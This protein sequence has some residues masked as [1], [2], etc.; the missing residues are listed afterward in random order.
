M[1]KF[2][3]TL[4]SFLL[5][6]SASAGGEGF[7]AYTQSG[8]EQELLNLD[9]IDGRVRNRQTAVQWED[10]LTVPGWWAR[11]A[12]KPAE[13]FELTHASNQ[14]GGV[15]V[16]VD[17]ANNQP[18]ALG[19]LSTV[20]VPNVLLAVAVKNE[21]G[22]V[23]T[24]AT[25]RLNRVQWFGGTGAMQDS[26]TGSWRL[27]GATAGGG[28]WTALEGLNMQHF[29]NVGGRLPEPIYLE[30]TVHLD[31]IKW[32]PGQLLWLRW[33]D[34]RVSGGNAA[35][36]IASLRIVGTAAGQGATAQGTVVVTTQVTTG[37]TAQ[38]VRKAP[39]A[40]PSTTQADGRYCWIPAQELYLEGRGWSDTESFFD[41]LPVHAKGK[42]RPAVWG[43]SQHSSGMAVRFFSNTTSVGVR[44]SL[45]KPD[46]QMRH[47]PS[48]G[49]SGLDLYV[50]E[51][52]QWKWAGN[53]APTGVEGNEKGMVAGLSAEPRE[54][55]LCLPLYNGITSLEI[56]LDKE[57][58]CVAAKPSAAPVVVYG[59]SITQGACASRP[60]TAYAAVLR[61]RLDREFINLGFSANGRMEK[62]MI[63]LL[64]ELSPAAYVLDP[65]PNLQPGEVERVEQCVVQIRKTHPNTPIV[66][67]QSIAYEH[68][69]VSAGARARYKD[70]N[71]ALTEIYERLKPSD[72]NLYLVRS[73][74]LLD[75]S[76][77]STVDGTHPNDIGFRSIAD[78]IEPVLR[79]ALAGGKG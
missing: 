47:M 55:L 79:K 57:A 63:E 18:L 54:Y 7:I 58:E 11:A 28:G 76:N 37:A 26:N 77:D 6:T 33:V 22:G 65:L 23:L 53:A 39:A 3:L 78:A 51:D 27:G 8:S 45:R 60:G 49:V 41:R 35:A 59:T 72:P 1:E 10:G 71:A 30:Q 14:T 31:A 40:Q 75:G 24:Q 61:R 4:L 74:N 36:G 19:S 2:I 42:V 9:G 62:E 48:T 20:Q 56:R 46:L 69:W 66:L 67:V 16:Y 68:A 52:G 43:L 70:S 32:V 17:G 25:I 44:W 34:N 64:C 5:I 73:E 29:V 50:K 15:Q 21:T 13:S 38:G 12:D